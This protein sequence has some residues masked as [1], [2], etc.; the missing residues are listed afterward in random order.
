MRRGGLLCGRIG[1]RLMDQGP[2][3]RGSRSD[4]IIGTA[5]AGVLCLGV[6]IVVVELFARLIIWAWPA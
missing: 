5:V 6:S 3:R 4:S 2:K 1:T